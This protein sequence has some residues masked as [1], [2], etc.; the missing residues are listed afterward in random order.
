MAQD[1]TVGVRELVDAANAEIE[2]LSLDEASALLGRDDVVFVDLR[3]VR[4]LGRE[5]KV[6]GALRVPDLSVEVPN[7]ILP[8]G[9]VDVRPVR[10]HVIPSAASCPI[11]PSVCLP[12]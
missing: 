4:E 3:D 12:E 2:T 9:L 6:A 5:G 8:C 7:E 10:T 11:R 1:I